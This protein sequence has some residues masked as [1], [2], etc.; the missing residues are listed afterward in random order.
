MCFL[1]QKS[2]QAKRKVK[3]YEITKDI[4]DELNYSRQKDHLQFKEDPFNKNAHGTAENMHEVLLIF[5]LL[6]T[7]FQVMCISITYY[8]L[9][10]A[11]KKIE[12]I[13]EEVLDK[14]DEF[15]KYLFDNT[16]MPNYDIRV[17]D[18]MFK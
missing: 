13:K 10:Y 3:L 16:I 18:T 14:F 1:N 4:Y 9:F 7:K 5:K 6:Q 2:L 12:M 8:D 11:V 17:N 15:F